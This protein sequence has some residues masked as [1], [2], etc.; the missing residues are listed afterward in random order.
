M[1]GQCR[2]QTPSVVGRDAEARRRIPPVGR[3][4]LA[5]TFAVNVLACP[6]CEGRMKLRA[7]VTDPASIAR[8]LAALGEA[9]EVPRRSANRGPPSWESRVLRRH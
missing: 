6:R 4:L 1:F 8:H 2:G 5:R 7:L 3:G 9:T